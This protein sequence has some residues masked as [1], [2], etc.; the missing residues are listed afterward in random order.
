MALNY[1]EKIALDNI[2]LEYVKA[3]VNAKSEIRPKSCYTHA[4]RV[5]GFDCFSM[6]SVRASLH[7][8][9]EKEVDTKI[10]EIDGHFY[11]DARGNDVILLSEVKFQV[12]KE[13]NI[14]YFLDL[15]E[16]VTYDF[17]TKKFSKDF[18]GNTIYHGGR[19]NIY[20]DERLLNALS[21]EW[22]FNY[23]D[24]LYAIYR[25]TLILAEEEIE[26]EPQGLA[27][28]LET[29]KFSIELIKK[30][31]FFSKYGKFGKFALMLNSYSSACASIDN[32]TEFLKDYTFDVL[33]KMDRWDL[34]N[35]Y[36]P[37][38]RNMV[39]L[40]D[41]YGKCRRKK[42]QRINLDDNRPTMYNLKMLDDILNEEKN[43]L[44][45]KQMQKLN[46]INGLVDEN[47]VVIVPQT[48]RDKQEEGIM[49]HN[50]VGSYYDD[51]I[52]DG[53]NYIY[54]IR[55]KN[56]PNKSYV[57]CRYNASHKET[58]EARLEGNRCLNDTEHGSVLALIKNI[59]K[60]ISEHYNELTEPNF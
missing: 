14:L 15:G 6:L 18:I 30:L 50:C 20:N 49:Q 53:R 43:E 10:S 29:E 16:D 37:S 12:K 27:K 58:V 52:I 57:T 26:K 2:I 42:N 33:I 32:I 54:F 38:L 39:D 40:L 44:L 3:T 45:A 25:T 36:A 55:R 56:S 8:L 35:G 47:F 24:N 9:A 51:S 46:F 4:L 41:L 1:N 23:S 17:I 59:D 48:Q 5:L 11:Y 13:K 21:H 28:A 22:L 7:R 60:L 19:T 34:L 31:Y